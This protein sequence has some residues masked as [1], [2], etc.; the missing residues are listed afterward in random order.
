MRVLPGTRPQIAKLIKDIEGIN[1]SDTLYEYVRDI[2]SFY[3]SEH[4]S[5][6]EILIQHE[7]DIEVLV[8]YYNI[9]NDFLNGYKPQNELERQMNLYREPNPRYEPVVSNIR[10]ALEFLIWESS[11]LKI[12]LPIETLESLGL[13]SI[14][15]RPLKIYQFKEV[16]HKCNTF[17]EEWKEWQKINRDAKV[18]CVIANLYD[19]AIRFYKVDGYIVE[20]PD[21]PKDLQRIFRFNKENYWDFCERCKGEKLEGVA[22]VYDS[23]DY[24]DK[25]GA[26]RLILRYFVTTLI[27]PNMDKKEENKY[28]MRFRRCLGKK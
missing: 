14:R 8:R 15:K 7:M 2:A 17:Y 18:E 13:R 6:N 16:S 19:V 4:K 3:T 10:Q 11:K 24:L 5:R 12:F 21:I 25:S 27:D 9:Y 20:Y 28:Y 26:E 22:S 1:D 23:V